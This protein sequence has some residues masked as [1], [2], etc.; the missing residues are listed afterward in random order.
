MTR[1][2]VR[3]DALALAEG[4]AR[5]EKAGG[6]ASIPRTVVAVFGHCSKK[7]IGDQFM[8]G[9]PCARKCYRRAAPLNAPFGPRHGQ[10]A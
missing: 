6:I 2:P 1:V 5:V 4:R 3:P 7:E 8:L 10:Q 9:Q